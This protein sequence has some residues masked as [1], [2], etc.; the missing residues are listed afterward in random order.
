MVKD[1]SLWVQRWAIW[2]MNLFANR[3]YLPGR[4][5]ESTSQVNK[6]APLGLV[7]KGIEFR[8]ILVEIRFCK[9]RDLATPPQKKTKRREKK[10]EV[11]VSPFGTD[12]CRGSRGKSSYTSL[13]TYSAQYPTFCQSSHQTRND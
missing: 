2:G 12:L 3:L 6:S 11:R 9:K 1:A 10:K 4:F 13:Q 7:A 5:D 8:I